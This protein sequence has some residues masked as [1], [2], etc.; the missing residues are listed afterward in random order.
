MHYHFSQS[1]N[2]KQLIPSILAVLCSISLSYGQQVGDFKPLRYNED[3]RFLAGDTARDWYKRMKYLPLSSNRN[4][5]VSFGADVRFQYFYINN[6]NFK[7]EP[8]D[9]DGYLL[10]RLL[11][12]SDLHLGQ[13]VRT[14]I[15]LQSS[16]AGS[17]IF[18]SPVDDNPLELHQAFIDVSNRS[19]A[20]LRLTLRA[21]RQELFY[22]SQRL[23]SVREGPNNRQSFDGVKLM[24]GW[25]N[26]LADFFVSHYVAARKG[27][28]DD[29][30]NGSTHFRGSY[31]T[32]QKVPFVRNVD[33]YYLG[34]QRPNAVFNSTQG[35]EKRHS[36][37]ARFFG[38]AGNWNYDAETV[39]QF[40]SIGEQNIAA[41]TASLNASYQFKHWALQPQLG[42]K[43]EFISG[44][45]RADDDKLQTFNPL[46]PRGGYFGLASVIGPSNLFD[47]H[48]SVTL[49]L[50]KK[51]SWNFDSDL[52][53]RYSDQDGIYGPS[54]ALLYSGKETAQ[55]HI[56]SQ[57]ATD[58][59]FVPNLFLYFR[60]EFTWLKAGGYLKEIGRDNDIL[61]AG[62]TTQLK[63]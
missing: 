48:P 19:A 54:T 11:V 42:L 31:W 3:Y 13:Q 33:L 25:K 22:G 37:G 38:K 23:V 4:R 59:V 14:F 44:D 12:H 58:L 27:I 35:K 2:M 61:F 1:A 16:G 29:K 8:K 39:Y 60:A 9:T 21:G 46:F 43:T 32:F 24:A 41:W 45:K 55:R 5:F 47:I 6:E 53:W 26:V 10:N 62:V 36:V 34:L 7:E 15:E 52:F 56:G 40:G 49:N 20:A 63:L 50:S 51:L 28:F 18:A 17:R 30:F 57:F